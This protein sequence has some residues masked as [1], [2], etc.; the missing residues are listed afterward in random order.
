MQNKK[1]D[2]ESKVVY[3]AT[4]FLSTEAFWSKIKVRN[5]FFLINQNLQMR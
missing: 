2:T 1:F 5:V 3:R 4:K